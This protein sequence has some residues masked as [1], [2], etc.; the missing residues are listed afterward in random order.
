MSEAASSPG[1]A[2]EAAER[3]PRCCPRHTDWTTL[4][5]HLADEFPEVAMDDLVREVSSAKEAVGH[6]SMDPDAALEIGELIVRHQLMMRS[7]RIAEVA[8]LDPERHT[9]RT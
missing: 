3:L 4:T 1:Q 2:A 8:R 7:G 6:V 9:Q 5:R